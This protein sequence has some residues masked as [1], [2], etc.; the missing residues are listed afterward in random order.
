MRSVFL[1]KAWKG[2]LWHFTAFPDFWI[3]A[4]TL[5]VQI[6]AMQV[7][8]TSESL[9]VQAWNIIQ[10]PKHFYFLKAHWT[11]NSHLALV[12]DR[13]NS[14]FGTL[15]LCLTCLAACFKSTK[16]NEHDVI[17]TVT[18]P[19]S[20][21]NG[22]ISKN[23]IRHVYNFYRGGIHWFLTKAVTF[24]ATEVMT[25]QSVNRFK[26]CFTYSNLCCK[27]ATSEPW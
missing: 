23:P 24:T 12:T 21:Q 26:I 8:T 4:W 10:K 9:I 2:P 18:L 17:I 3:S 6:E 13:G 7:C 14:L 22:S 5:S 15:L 25:S 27:M 16:A 19:N 11:I 1:S 20:K